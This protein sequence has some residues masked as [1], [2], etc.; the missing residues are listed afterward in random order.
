MKV[1]VKLGTVCLNVVYAIFKV[2]PLQHKLVMISRQSNKPSIDF[3]LLKE[4]LEK[5]DAQLRIVV[6]CKTLDG[7]L[8]SSL[9]AKI[10]YGFHMIVQMYH[11]ATSQVAILDTYC[12]VASL[13]KHRKQLK[14][15]QIW[16]SIGTMKKFGYTALDTEEGSRT[17]I[18]Q[19]MQM[20]KHYSYVFASSSAY[21]KD[22]AAG[23]HCDEK[24]VRI[25]PLPRID[26]LRDQAYKQQMQDKIYHL[27]PELKDRK[28]IV[29][30]PTFRKNEF[31]MQTALNQ[32][33]ACIKDEVLVL[34]LHPLS[35]IS[36]HN[37]HVIELKEFTTFDMLFVA[38]AVISDYSCVVFEAALLSIPLYFYNFDM[39]KYAKNRG[40]AID[41]NNELPGVISD[42]AKQIMNAIQHIPY[43]MEELKHFA[44][45]YVVCTGSASKQMAEFIVSLLEK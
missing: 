8:K 18:A 32:L 25:Y 34:K 38:D 21:Q 3:V 45:K 5:E 19:L 6:L 2:F 12:I 24:I 9:T 27:H 15:I 28:I 4:A 35:K 43:N 40:L 14:I 13:L 39:D 31:R 11:L 10:A 30:C 44:D 29:Y 33:S 7:G 37:E 26:L 20:H 17:S 41:Y 16:H 22:L 36:I 1:I 42:D 23:F